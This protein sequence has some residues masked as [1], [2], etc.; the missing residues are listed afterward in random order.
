VR[1]KSVVFCQTEPLFGIF[2]TGTETGGF[3]GFSKTQVKIEKRIGVRIGR[4]S[5]ILSIGDKKMG[6]KGL[7]KGHT[8][9]F[10]KLS[11]VIG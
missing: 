2:S 6:K 10:D 5:L 4:I 1:C 3:T 8:E 7:S 9:L 11:Q